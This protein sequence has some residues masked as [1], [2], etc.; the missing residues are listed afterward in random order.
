MGYGNPIYIYGVDAFLRDALEAGVDG[1]I[2]V[3]LLFEEDE[4]LCFRRCGRRT[5]SGCKRRHRRPAV[6]R[7]GKHLG[8]RLL[9][10]HLR[11]H[12]HRSA[13]DEA[14]RAAVERLKRHTDLPVAVGSHQDGRRVARISSPADA[15]VGS[16]IVDRI[17]ARRRRIGGS[18]LV[19]DVLAFVKELAPAQDVQ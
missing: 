12:R 3:D 11:D 4:E 5:L 17:R 1:L 14:V 9:R 15:V 7:P 13:D 8:L 10:L 19:D 18:G 2:V 6:H 16:A